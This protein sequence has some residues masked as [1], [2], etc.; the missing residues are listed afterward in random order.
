M[1]EWGDVGE[2]VQTSSY[3]INKFCGCDAQ[4]DDYYNWEYRIIYLKVIINNKVYLKYS[5]S[6]KEMIIMWCDEGVGSCCSGNH[7]SMYKCV[8]LTHF[9]P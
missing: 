8:K 7:F 1:G 3:K 6:K 9:T 2:S 4:H 5:Y